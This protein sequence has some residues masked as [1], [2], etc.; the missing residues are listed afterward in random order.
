[1]KPAHT[2]QTERAGKR[3]VRSRLAHWVRNLDDV[4][5]RMIRG[6]TFTAGSALI[7]RLITFFAG[8][9]AARV[10]G[11]AA[12]GTFS[13]CQST[14]TLA[15]AV[16][17]MGLPWVITRVIAAYRTEN[18]E[19]AYRLWRVLTLLCVGGVAVVSIGALS[20]AGPLTKMT[21][22]PAAGPA[23]LVGCVVLFTGY[24]INNFSQA[25]LM[26]A[27]EFTLAAKWG[28][29]RSL[30]AAGGLV[31]GV[32]V[33]GPIHA[34]VGYALGEYVVLVPLLR[35]GH[36]LLRAPRLGAEST[37]RPILTNDIW[38]M[39]AAAWGSTLLL[40]PALWYSQVLLR[41]SAD[42]YTALGVFALSQRA[43]QAVVMVPGSIALS[44]VPILTECWANGRPDDFGRSARKYAAGYLAYVVPVTLVVA[45]SAPF[46]LLLFGR[47]YASAWP[48]F[49][50]LVFAAV[51]MVMNNLLSTMAIAMNRSALWLL[52]DLA[53]AVALLSAAV[54]LIP[55][56]GGTGASL[57]YLMAS[58]VTCLALWPVARELRVRS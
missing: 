9:V 22:G 57:S 35:Q 10:L 27:Q 55:M 32:S 31:G 24:A 2:V 11:A 41:R 3:T 15:T 52:S 1:L 19:R 54:C 45:L 50:V 28:I 14:V 36:A 13:L 46:T 34:V 25:V 7:S 6:A 8:L 18:P 5:G 26:G 51:P 33:G 12:F 53:Q 39:A 47:T 30:A 56:I 48:V 17:G 4:S 29:A 58:M 49:V 37:S 21:F 16:A 42:G 20:A 23:L 44:S 40:H 43:V 38:Q